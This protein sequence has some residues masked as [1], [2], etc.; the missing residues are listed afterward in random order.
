MNQSNGDMFCY[1][2]TQKHVLE[3][4]EMGHEPCYFYS[5][6][7]YN[8]DMFGPLSEEMAYKGFYH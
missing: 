1:V 6:D 4:A 3:C 7:Y 8:P 5:F 2:D